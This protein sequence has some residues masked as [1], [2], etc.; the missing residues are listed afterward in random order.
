MMDISSLDIKA[1]AAAAAV[2]TLLVLYLTIFA[3]RSQYRK[4]S[5]SS[6]IKDFLRV[7]CIVMPLLLLLMFLGM[8]AIRSDYPLV[9]MPG[10]LGFPVL[11][12]WAGHHLLNLRAREWKRKHPQYATLVLGKKDRFSTSE[13]IQL[14]SL[15]HKKPEKDMI[16]ITTEKVRHLP[17]QSSVKLLIVPGQYDLELSWQKKNN[18]SRYQ[19]L[20][21]VLHQEISIV[22][23]D[24]KTCYIPIPE[25]KTGFQMEELSDETQI[26]NPNGKS[27]NWREHITS[28]LLGLLSLL[29]FI[30]IGVFH[31]NDVIGSADKYLTSWFLQAVIGM[32]FCLFFTRFLLTVRTWSQGPRIF[33]G[34]LCLSL[35]IAFAG[36]YGLRGIYALQ[37]SLDTPKSLTMAATD[38][39]VGYIPR[40]SFYQ[41]LYLEEGQP[42]IYCQQNYYVINNAM[43]WE[44]NAQIDFP[45]DKE[46]I[47]QLKV[48]PHTRVVHSYSF[49]KTHSSYHPMRTDQ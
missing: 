9:A 19:S 22:V 11:L 33:L 16:C 39:E 28:L 1:F 25:E 2:F 32:A 35:L 49:N 37:D 44:L 26:E 42:V 4:V 13:Y 14:L 30:G 38:F 45:L 10:I 46:Q 34:I 23:T 3:A 15:N 21:E 48:F 24:G 36:I 47:L 7:E 43:D 31:P 41:G 6:Y 27:W 12:G 29:A 40:S 5:F 18:L 8:A 20:T 17:G